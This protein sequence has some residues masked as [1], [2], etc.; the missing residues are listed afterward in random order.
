MRTVLFA[1]LLLVG[2]AASADVQI[3]FRDG[4][5][6]QCQRIVQQDNRV[7]VVER[8]GKR[9]SIQRK[10]IQSMEEIKTAPGPDAPKPADQPKTEQTDEDKLV[11]TDENVERTVPRLRYP[12]EQEAEEQQATEPPPVTISVVSQQVSRSEGTV[13]FE[14]TAR[15]DLTDVANNV[16]MTVQALDANGNVV[17]SSTS[18]LAG[19]L[20]EGASVPFSFQFADA[21]NTISRFTFQFEA[22]IGGTPPQ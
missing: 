6:F 4:S 7:V 8:D 19:S 1:A 18:R 2:V 11:L 10:L 12:P 5:V 3:T 13:R 22:V 15:N 16:Q 17:A 20:E 14:G 21:N 9:L